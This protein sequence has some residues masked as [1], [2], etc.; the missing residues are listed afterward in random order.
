MNAIQNFVYWTWVWFGLV[1]TTA[2]RST[3]LSGKYYLAP[4]HQFLNAQE[5]LKS[6][7]WAGQGTKAEWPYCPS[8]GKAD[9][10]HLMQCQNCGSNVGIAVPHRNLNNAIIYMVI[11]HC[12]YDFFTI[13][14]GTAFL[15]LAPQFWHLTKAVKNG[16]FWRPKKANM[17]A[18]K[19]DIPR[20]HAGMDFLQKTGSKLV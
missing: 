16:H 19:R 15:T 10:P 2:Y 5:R 8:S 13:S 11:D 12:S 9:W 7:Q 3:T 14:Y 20:I 4:Y 6:F 18:K 17:R 1:L